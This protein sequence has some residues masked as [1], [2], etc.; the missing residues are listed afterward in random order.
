MRYGLLGNTVKERSQIRE[1]HF[2]QHPSRDPDWVEGDQIEFEYEPLMLLAA[3]I[4][5]INGERP[6]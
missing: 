5:S 3:Y 2:R 6:L 1:S 4:V